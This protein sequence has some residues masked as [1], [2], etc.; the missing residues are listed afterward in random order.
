[1]TWF[2]PQ[3]IDGS[4]PPTATFYHNQPIIM[5]SIEKKEIN[6]LGEKLTSRESQ[7]IVENH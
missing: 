4:A 7:G 5:N 3:H 2:T 6:S 1:M